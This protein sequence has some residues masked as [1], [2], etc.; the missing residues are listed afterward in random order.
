MIEI[1][2]SQVAIGVRTDLDLDDVTEHRFAARVLEHGIA[3]VASFQWSVEGTSIDAVVADATS[4]VHG[5]WAETAL[6]ELEPYLGTP[7]LVYVYLQRGRLYGR[8]ASDERDA[9]GAAEEWVRE[10]FPAAEPAEELRI[11]IRFW[12]SG[13][14]GATASSRSIDVSSWDA[15]AANYP[16]ATRSALGALMAGFRPASGGQLLLWHGPPGTGKT[17]ALRA[18]GWEWRGWCDLHYVT[19]PEYFFGASTYMLDVLLREDDDDDEDGSRWRLLVLEDTGELLAADAKERTGQGLSRLLNV[20][21]GII[22]QGL[23]VL[24]LV[25]TNEAL[26]TLHPAVARP[27][28][29]A[30]RIE[31]VP[32]PADEAAAWLRA[33]G[34]EDARSAATLAELYALAEGVEMPERPPFGFVT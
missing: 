13:G 32:F 27:G 11:P 17:H 2:E 33:A 12:S 23:R 5:R 24:V 19:D 34:R 25:T 1:E 18:L 8:A 10:R 7:C 14:R 16:R 9:L 4:T 26:R 3:H 22:G 29:C 6:L 20:V 30:S 28:R 31:F 21:D 15:V